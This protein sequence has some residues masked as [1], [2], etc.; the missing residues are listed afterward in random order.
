M[1]KRILSQVLLW[2][3]LIIL[4]SQAAFEGFGIGGIVGLQNL[5]GRHFYT[6]TTTPDN[7]QVRRLG[8][9]AGLYGLYARYY[10][11]L[12]GKFIVGAEASVIIPGANP[13]IDLILNNRGGVEGTAKIQHTRSINFML[14]VGMMLNPKIL[15][16]LNAGIEMAR[17]QFTYNFPN[18]P[19]LPRTQTLGHLFKAPSFALGAAYKISNHILVGIEAGTS[20]YKRY[21]IH[22]TPPRAYHYKPAEYRA[23]FKVTYQF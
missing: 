8:A 12:P 19:G 21:K 7:D 10:I 20:L 13:Q 2:I 22:M 9:L 15:A 5:R 11:E 23:L 1:K 18:V 3:T 16:Y 14:T 6:G 17:F 4:P